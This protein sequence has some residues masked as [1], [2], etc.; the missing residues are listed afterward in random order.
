MHATVSNRLQAVFASTAR[1]SASFH[2]FL[3]RTNVGQDSRT[4]E[5]E[6]QLDV[7]KLSEH[8]SWAPCC[9]LMTSQLI[10]LDRDMNSSKD[11]TFPSGELS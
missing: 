11:M 5:R 4:V 7:N 9:C 1:L 2:F 10:Q 6:L 8:Q 3:H